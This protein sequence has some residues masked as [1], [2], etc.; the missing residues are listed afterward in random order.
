M[1]LIKCPECQREISDTSVSCPGCG[2]RL[3]TMSDKSIKLISICIIIIII[4]GSIAFY[5]YKENKHQEDLKK[6]TEDLKKANDN[7]NKYLDEN[8]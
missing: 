5:N 3:K 1:S 2:Y 6:Q 8:K 4:I 7:L